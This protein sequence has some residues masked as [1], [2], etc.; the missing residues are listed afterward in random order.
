[1]AI[2]TAEPRTVV[3]MGVV[4]WLLIPLVAVLVALGWTSWL[5][6]RERQRANEDWRARRL[7][8]LGPVLAAT[9]VVDT[10]SSRVEDS[11]RTESADAARGG[12]V[13]ISTVELD[14]TD[15]E[16]SDARP[17][18]GQSVDQEQERTAGAQIRIDE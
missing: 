8:Q 14:L 2:S 4:V 5:A 6:R 16:P 13:T 11:T 12:S 3:A 15:D 17:S 7:A 10:D 9:E 18:T 1:M